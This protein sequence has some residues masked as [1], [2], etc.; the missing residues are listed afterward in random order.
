[1]S[2]AKR[3]RSL[4]EESGK[5]KK[6]LAEVMLDIAVLKDI[7]AKSGDA[8]SKA[9]GG[10]SCSVSIQ[11]KRASGVRHYW[12][13]PTRQQLCVTATGWRCPTV[14]LRDL[15]SEHRCFGY[16]RLCEAAQGSGDA[17]H[18]WK[19]CGGY[20]LAREGITPN[21]RNVRIYRE[22]GLKVRRRSGRKRALGTRAPM[23]VPQMPNQR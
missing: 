2:E 17:Q 21:R 15:A 12:R 10:D 22:E 9:G 23:T 19:G 16:P 18:R 5:L 14:R 11:A 20:P 13:V 8:R 4:E 3:L 6:L 1:V 7:T